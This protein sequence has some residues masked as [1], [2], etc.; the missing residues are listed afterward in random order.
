MPH[1]GHSGLVRTRLRVALTR[2]C[3]W[4]LLPGYNTF[5]FAE[6]VCSMHSGDG[7]GRGA[8]SNCQPAITEVCT[9]IC[10]ATTPQSREA[11][12]HPL[13]LD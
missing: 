3:V 8:Q 12:P 5:G 11:D 9:D 7:Q 1:T 6:R 13:F 4:Y 2:F 10:L